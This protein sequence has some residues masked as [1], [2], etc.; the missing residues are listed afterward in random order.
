MKLL[1][2]SNSHLCQFNQ[3]PYRMFIAQNSDKVFGAVI[4]FNTIQMMN[5][6][7]FRQRSLM[8]LFPNQMMFQLVLCLPI[9]STNVDLPIAFPYICSTASPILRF[10]SRC[11]WQTSLAI[12][13]LS[14]VQLLATFSAYATRCLQ[15]LN[16]SPITRHNLT[17]K[18]ISAIPMCKKLSVTSFAILNM[19]HRI[20]IPQLAFIIKYEKRP[21]LRP[22]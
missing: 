14:T 8:C 9:N 19:F 4:I 18:A 10:F 16:I 21:E 6:I 13:A 2:L 3:C 12:S 15:H 17:I 5:Q 7:S 1:Q 20:T 11:S 22:E